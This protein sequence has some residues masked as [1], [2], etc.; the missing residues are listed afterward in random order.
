MKPKIT[1]A[2]AETQREG[3]TLL[4]SIRRLVVL[5]EFATFLSEAKK[6]HLRP[7]HKTLNTERD[8]DTLMDA[9]G[10]AKMA[11]RFAD[12][13]SLIEKLTKDS[14]EYEQQEK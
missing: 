5:P 2:K 4:E 3:F 11:R 1:L 14:K 9:Q 7:V 8:H 6:V 10:Q 13:N 12:V